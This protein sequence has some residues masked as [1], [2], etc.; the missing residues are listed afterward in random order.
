MDRVQQLLKMHRVDFKYRPGDTVK[1][2]TKVVEG[3]TE[4]I[5]VFDG[6]II[7]IRGAGVARTFTVRKTSYGVG[8]ERVFPMNSPRI[9]RVELVK[10]GKV[11]RAKLNYIREL[12]GKASRLDEKNVMETA[13][14]A[15]AVQPEIPAQPVPVQPE[16]GKSAPETK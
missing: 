14:S 1:V 13:A 6:V 16:A 5:Q 10:S 9:D 2:H 15:A 12:E 3:D 7:A 4:R 8:V 11:R